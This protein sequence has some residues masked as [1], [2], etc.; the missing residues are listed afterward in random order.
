MIRR[1][2]SARSIEPRDPCQVDASAVGARGRLSHTPS[3]TARLKG[4]VCVSIQQCN[5]SGPACRLG[6]PAST[7]NYDR[8]TRPGCWAASPG[9]GCHV[10]VSC[11]IILPR[12]TRRGCDLDSRRRHQARPPGARMPLAEPQAAS[13]SELVRSSCALALPKQNAA[14]C[15]NCSLRVRA[16]PILLCDPKYALAILNT[17]VILRDPCHPTSSYVILHTLVILHT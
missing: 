12:P 15:R 16:R 11:C 2:L 10:A 17:L 14:A 13:E 5:C 4:P 8:N 3:V 9:A 6:W 1:A 7:H